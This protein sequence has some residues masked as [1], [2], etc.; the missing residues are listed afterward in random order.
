LGSAFPSTIDS[1]A[2]LSGASRTPS[3]IHHLVFPR[4]HGAWGMLLVPLMTGGILGLRT[5]HDV[6]SLAL[7]LAASL[8]LFCLR[9]PFESLMSVSAYRVRNGHERRAAM[10]AIAVYA[11]VTLA[12]ATALMMRVEPLPLL[13][14]GNAAAL[15]FAAQLM[16]RRFR[17]QDRC[18]AQLIGSAALTA[19]AAAGYYVAAQ[20]WSATALLVW[21]ANWLF[22][23]NQIHYVQLRIH[24]ASCSSRLQKLQRGL[25]FFFG[26]VVLA[27]VL[28]AGAEVGALPWAAC[29]AYLPLLVRG[30]AWFV[31][32][33]APLAIR[34]LGFSELAHAVAFGVLLIAVL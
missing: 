1:R 24:A 30:T 27:A 31:E 28:V 10:A 34:R 5:G 32:P 11:V 25:H 16:V 7:L 3:R 6:V 15:G 23:A 8:S 22:A 33:P 14:L 17:A 2:G 29:V 13:F 9:T 26:Q 19:A 21:A 18:L 20:H 12:C 4:E